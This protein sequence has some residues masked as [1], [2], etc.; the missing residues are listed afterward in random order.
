MRRWPKYLNDFGDLRRGRFGNA[1]NANG[2]T[3]PTRTVSI[4]AG[5]SISGWSVW[6]LPEFDLRARESIRPRSCAGDS[7][8]SWKKPSSIDP[9]DE[10]KVAD[11]L[12][13]LAALRGRAG[14]VIEMEQHA[15]AHDRVRL[16]NGESYPFL[17]SLGM[18][19]IAFS[20][21]ATCRRPRD[22]I[23]VLMN[24]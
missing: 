21:Y 18:K 8:L 23:I 20:H 6:R 11:L 4:S 1:G 7:V 9:S 17:Q 13:S 15:A 3:A 16:G 12:I 14:Q 19:R 2:T 22:S 10:D 24:G 5:E